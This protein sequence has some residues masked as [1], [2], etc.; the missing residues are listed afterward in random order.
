MKNHTRFSKASG[1][2]KAK[3]RKLRQ[4]GWTPGAGYIGDWLRSPKRQKSHSLN[5][6]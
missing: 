2:E 4:R 5:L 1:S 6:V 3:L